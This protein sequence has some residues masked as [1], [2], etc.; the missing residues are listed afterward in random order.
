MKSVLAVAY[1]SSA[2]F[3]LCPFP[4]ALAYGGLALWGLPALLLF[5]LVPIIDMLAPDSA[6]EVDEAEIGYIARAVLRCLP[7]TFV[8]GQVIALVAVG[9][10]AP[11]LTLGELLMATLSLGATGSV[12]I[13]AAHDLTHRPPRWSDPYLLVGRLGLLAEAYMHFEISHWHGHHRY[14]CTAADDSTG[15]RGESA[16][17]YLRR[18]VP[19]CFGR[20]WREDGVGGGLAEVLSSRV[21]WFTLMPPAVALLIYVGMGRAALLL[22]V[23]QAS[24]AILLL[25]MIS[26]I[27]HYGLRR[28]GP[29]GEAA[30]APQYVWDS[31]ALAS[32]AVTF[33]LPRHASHH[34]EVGAD[35]FRLKRRQTA[36]QLPV[37]YPAAVTMA[38][39]PPLWFRIMNARLDDEDT[40]VASEVSGKG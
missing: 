14:V 18:T 8:L 9:R 10:A 13:A 40:G 6:L 30:M 22:Y 34:S 38:L 26:Y 27:Q 17:A 19:A 11:T 23:G 25:E 32:N 4:F 29:E 21:F 1:W 2:A 31:Y 16:F 39:L 7:A 20:A 37:G 3:L 24:I 36:R 35:Y 15:W 5:G 12:T 33:N 28:D